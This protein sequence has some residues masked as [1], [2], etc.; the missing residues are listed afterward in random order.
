MLLDIWVLSD[1]FYYLGTMWY[2]WLSGY[3]LSHLAI[4]ILLLPELILILF[5]YQ[6]CK[7]FEKELSLVLN[8]LKVRNIW[9]PWLSGYYL[10]LLAIWVLSVTLGYHYFTLL[11]C[12]TLLVIWVLSDALVCPGTVCYTWL[13]LFYFCLNCDLNSFSVS[14]VSNIWRSN[15]H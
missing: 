10:I 15:Y 12:L 9:H 4:T 1:A 11:Y 14:I 13:S 2:S 6:L 7:T 8:L 5:Q 3:F